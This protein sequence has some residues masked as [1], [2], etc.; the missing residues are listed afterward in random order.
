M[1]FTLFSNTVNAPFSN[2][3]FKILFT[4]STLDL[5]KIYL[6]PHVAIIGTTLGFLQGSL[7]YS[8]TGPLPHI[9]PSAPGPYKILASLS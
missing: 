9:R 7:G 3:Y 1:Y 2:R 8:A 4:N 6:F 5:S